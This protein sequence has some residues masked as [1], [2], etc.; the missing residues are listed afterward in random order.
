[1]SCPRSEGKDIDYLLLFSL[2]TLLVGFLVGPLQGQIKK[3]EQPLAASIPQKI[4]SFT[5]P[6]I[7]HQEIQDFLAALENLSLN[8]VS[9]FNVCYGLNMQCSPSPRPPQ[10]HGFNA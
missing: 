2:M 4:A 9:L 7:I 1:M 5:C 6:H 8:R 3:A 10:A